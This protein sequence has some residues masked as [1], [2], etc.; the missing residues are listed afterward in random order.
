MAKPTA[1][2]IV[3]AMAAIA[4]ALIFAGPAA[5]AGKGAA[6]KA[7]ASE[8]PMQIYIVRSAQDGC[9]PDCPE[10][11]AAQ[12]QIVAGTLAQFKS[13]VGRLGDRKL[14]VL[15][16]SGGGLAKEAMAMG[17]LLRGKGLDVAVARTA[18]ACAPESS[19]CRKKYSKKPVPALPDP[20]FSACASSC[21]FIFAAGSRRYVRP[22]A[23]VG[24][25]QSKL[26][27]RKIMYTYRMMPYR[28]ADG[29]IRLK[30][31]V[32][33]QKVVSEEHRKATNKTY[34]EYE[35]YFIEMGVSKQIMPLLVATPTDSIHWLTNDELRSTQIATHRMNGEQLVSRATAPED[36]WAGP[37]SPY[38]PTLGD[39]S[40]DCALRGLNCALDV[41]RP[42]PP[43][44]TSSSGGA[45][46]PI[47][48][49]PGVPASTAE[50]CTRTGRGC[51]W[52][53]TPPAPSR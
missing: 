5:G 19:A 30:K 1:L 8:P 46:A 20:G 29:S 26:I 23:Y 45:A 48:T 13:V 27:F 47:V 25:H 53:L 39:Q 2:R 6:K 34:S 41:N 10:W 51:S 14:P 37:I 40:P 17:R 36:G 15:I 9:D 33:S 11:I 44:A 18:F 42:L 32:L 52:Q 22:P 38:A 28:S 7:P 43:G 50:D 31:T 16:H 24:V 12:G 3:T 49:G 4:S 21:A 35:K